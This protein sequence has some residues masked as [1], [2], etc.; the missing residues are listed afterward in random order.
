MPVK[1][2]VIPAAGKGTRLLP[3]T[4]STPKEMLPVGDKPV[5]RYVVEEALGAG[6]EEILIITG[7]R[8]DMIKDYFSPYED[9][10][11]LRED[12]KYEELEAVEEIEEL[13]EHIQYKRQHEQEGLGHAVLQAEDFVGEDDFAI[14]FGDSFFRPGE[15]LL[16]DMIEVYEDYN[17]ANV[18]AAREY[19]KEELNEH[20]IME[21]EYV[22]EG[23]YEIKNAVEK[24]PID[25]APSNIGTGSRYVISSEVF[26]S[27]KEIEKGTDN[28]L[29]LTDAMVDNLK[30][31]G[32]RTLA[33][34]S[35]YKRY[36]MSYPNDFVE[37]FKEFSNY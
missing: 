14:L 28:E 13:G 23:V 1:K 7:E 10:E 31:E 5:I 16:K 11:Q 24:P 33:Y 6:I 21:V 17:G 18:V 12:G 2:A 34:I 25:E 36:H 35:P 8:G 37:T 30:K 9:K 27:L 4:K 19:P 29:Q 15:N 20:G 26:E 22:D 32:E 3:L